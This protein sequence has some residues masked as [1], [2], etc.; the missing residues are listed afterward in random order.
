MSLSFGNFI[1]PIW[2]DKGN[3]ST[4]EGL[5]TRITYL[6]EVMVKF[7]YAIE[8]IKEDRTEMNKIKDE[9]DKKDLTDGGKWKGNA[10]KAGETKQTNL[11]TEAKNADQRMGTLITDIENAKK[12]AETERSD[13][14]KKLEELRKK[15]K[16]G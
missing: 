9:F 13:C 15:Q 5:E 3:T 6:G 1:E 10:E 2:T 4:I 16:E 11:V 8:A 7:D 12:A 14:Q